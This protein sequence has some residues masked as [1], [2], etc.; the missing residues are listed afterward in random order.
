M[1]SG[2][3]LC[4]LLFNFNFLNEAKVLQVLH[5]LPNIFMQFYPSFT[6]THHPH[7]RLFNPHTHTHTHTYTPFVIAVFFFHFPSLPSCLI[8]LLW[9]LNQGQAVKMW[10]DSRLGIDFIFFFCLFEFSKRTSTLY[11]VVH[12]VVTPQWSR[13][14][15]WR[16]VP[17]KGVWPVTGGQCVVKETSVANKT[18]IKYSN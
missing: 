3:K 9:T 17:Y 15:H 2:L 11:S 7:N 1:S 18:Q 10:H 8:S 14:V 5:F 6:P 4:Q 13:V 16:L 12:S